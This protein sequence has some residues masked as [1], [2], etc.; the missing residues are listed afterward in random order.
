MALADTLLL[1]VDSFL[2]FC[3]FLDPML[4]SLTLVFDLFSTKLLL[5]KLEGRLSYFSEYC[6]ILIGDCSD[7]TACGATLTG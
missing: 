3:F 2:D 1:P 5:D 6:S 4:L 7:M